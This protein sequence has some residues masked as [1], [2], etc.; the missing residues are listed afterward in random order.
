[1]NLREDRWFVRFRGHT[2][3]PLTTDQVMTSLRNRELSDADKIASSKNPAWSAIGAHPAFAPFTETMRAPAVS[4]APIPPPQEIWQRKAR[5]RAAELATFTP[6][7]PGSIPGINAQTTQRATSFYPNYSEDSVARA[8]PGQYKPFPADPN[9]RVIHPAA[10]AEPAKKSKRVAGP[11]KKL[12]RPRKNPLPAAPA[13][14][15]VVDK[16]NLS[17]VDMVAPILEAAPASVAAPIFDVE[18]KLAP[19]PQAPKPSAAPPV[20]N[21]APASATP[22]APVAPVAPAS[23]AAPKP[24]ETTQAAA[25]VVPPRPN[26]AAATDFHV[27]PPAMPVRL[28]A[29][30]AAFEA[31][32][33][34]EESPEDLAENAAWAAEAEEPG[35]APYVAPIET[36]EATPVPAEVFETAAVPEPELEELPQEKPKDQAAI[37]EEAPAPPAPKVEAAAPA[38]ENLAVE[39]LALLESLRDWRRKEEELEQSLR[40]KNATPER[41]K[42]PVAEAFQPASEPVAAPAPPTVPALA[43]RVRALVEANWKLILVAAALAALVSLAVFFAVEKTRGPENRSF[44]DPS[45]PTAQ[46]AQKEDPTPSLR[47]PTRPQRD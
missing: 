33:V 23:V 27:P 40:A 7:E 14:A 1:M 19:S 10:P 16:S 32:P 9:A 44:P 35:P 26:F 41:P 45:S 38:Q 30:I 37:V 36:V 20:P 34:R 42:M 28:D 5:N 22:V 24:V 43:T 21:P 6:E 29:A 4:L 2:L 12:G 3:G 13:P 47:A 11:G 46:P 17:I 39:S 18:P 8:R 31:E 25:T 15:P